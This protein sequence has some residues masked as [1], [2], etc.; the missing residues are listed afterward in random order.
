MLTF[1]VVV[2]LGV[3]GRRGSGPGSDGGQRRGQ[4]GCLILAWLGIAWMDL[5][6]VGLGWGGLDYTVF[7]CLGL[8]WRGWPV[9]TLFGESQ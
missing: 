2:V 9:D 1:V 3:Q 5:D 4:G 7:G 6:W 8:A